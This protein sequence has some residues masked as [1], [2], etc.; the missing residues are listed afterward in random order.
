MKHK[1]RFLQPLAVEGTT[2]C[3]RMQTETGK[4]K[5]AGAARNVQLH[6]DRESAMEN[7]SDL[8][9]DLRITTDGA[10]GAALVRGSTL[11]SYAKTPPE[12]EEQKR[13]GK[14]K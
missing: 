1:K 4:A 14:N 7:G 11:Q 8:R 13:Q 10:Y 5:A 12:A 9:S 6:M 3:A 2:G